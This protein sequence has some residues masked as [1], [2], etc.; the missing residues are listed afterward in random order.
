M[1]QLWCQNGCSRERGSEVL[2]DVIQTS[3]LRTVV[4]FTPMQWCLNNVSLYFQIEFSDKRKKGYR[5]K[6]YRHVFPSFCLSMIRHAYH[7][8]G[9]F[10]TLCIWGAGGETH[11]FCFFSEVLLK[12]VQCDIEAVSCSE[13]GSVVAQAG[14]SAGLAGKQRRCVL[15]HNLFL[16]V[17]QDMTW[18][19]SN[20][21]PT[22]AVKLMLTHLIIF[23]INHV[24][25]RVQ[26]F[27]SQSF[28]TAPT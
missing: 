3:A 1:M 25:S 10:I 2:S 18:T 24:R 17:H 9:T 6:N 23:S 19:T 7:P 22:S 21:F 4:F 26:K 27:C 8:P 14:R 11:V 28:E 5:R 20:I 15:Q 12:R 16:I 13:R